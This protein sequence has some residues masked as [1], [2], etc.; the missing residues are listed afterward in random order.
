MSPRF[1]AHLLGRFH[2][3]FLCVVA[4]LCAGLTGCTA[5]VSP[6]NALPANRVPDAFLGTPRANDV[7]INL[8]RLR[9]EKPKEYLLDSD[10]ILAI[11]IDSVLG[12]E[13][14]APPVAFAQPRS[15]QPPPPGDPITVTGEGPL[16]QP[17]IDT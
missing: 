8:A 4:I 15:D 16:K 11:S 10:D 17:P 3:V 9:I 7:P 5:L 6:I 2:R 12:Q 1:R 13:G 14:E